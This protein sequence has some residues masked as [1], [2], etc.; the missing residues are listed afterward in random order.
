[1][2]ISTLCAAA[3]GNIIS[4]VAGIM[5]GT[6]IEDFCTHYLKLPMPNLTTA[7][8]QL[9]SVRFANQFGCGV[10]IVIGC[11]IG[12]FPL[13]FLDPN[14]NQKLKRDA[15]LQK[16]FRDIMSEAR[17]LIGAQSANMF[18][19]VDKVPNKDGTAPVPNPD[20]RFLYV[21]YLDSDS[22]EVSHRSFK[23]GKGIVSRSALTGQ[24]WNIKDVETEPD[25]SP[26][27]QKDKVK[28]LVCVPVLNSEGKTFAVIRAYNKIE[29]GT[30]GSPTTKKRD[31]KEIQRQGFTA[32][33][34]QVLQALASHISVSLQHMYQERE[35]DES[36]G[37]K[38]TIRI[39]KEHGLAG[40][41]EEKPTP[42]SR[43]QSL[44][45]EEEGGEKL[46]I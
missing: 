27:M 20:G 21:K 34:V 22:G 41:A 26:E 1:M 32:N 5:L 28:N 4:D 16:I 46:M 25:F 45:P 3:I 31:S 24:T 43:R 44:F 14:K 15:A 10:G 18:L 37:V 6:V 23:F 19:L 42:F 17:T 29:E 12:M 30:L 36:I 8:R 2:G 33:D 38:E 13:L 35:A 40:I 39:L 11:I 7:Q 9:R